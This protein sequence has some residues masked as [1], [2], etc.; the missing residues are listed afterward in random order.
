MWGRGAEGKGEKQ[1][2]GN[3]PLQRRIERL[4]GARIV[5]GGDWE[6]GSEQ[7]VK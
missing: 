4:D 7:D 2:G 5:G 1:G 3:P 6:E